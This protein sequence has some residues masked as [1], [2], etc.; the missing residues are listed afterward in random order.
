VYVQLYDDTG[1]PSGSRTGLT[2]STTNASRTVTS[3]NVYYI[4]VTP[5]ASGGSGTYRIGFT[6][7]TT[8]P[9]KIT[10]PTTGVTT[11]TVDVWADGNIAT[12][13]KEQWFKF[14]ATAATQYI[15][16]KSGEMTS[17]IV[18]LFDNTGTAVGNQ[19]T[20][21]NSSSSISRTVTV[22]NVYYIKVN[23]YSGTGAY[24]ILF[25]TSTVPTAIIPTTGVTT[26]TYDVWSN[27]IIA[28]SDGEQWFKFTATAA[29]QYIHFNRNTFPGVYVQ[30]YNNTGIPV[31]EQ[32]QIVNN[33]NISITVTNGSVYYIKATPYSSNGIYMIGFNNSSTTYPKIKI[34]TANVTTLSPDVWAN[35]NIDVNGEQWY[36]FTATS[37]RQHIHFSSGTLSEVYAA[38]YTNN[39]TI[40]GTPSWSLSSKDYEPVTIG[41]VY[42]IKVTPT[43]NSASGT[44]KIGVTSSEYVQ[45]EGSITLTLNVLSNGNITT[46]GG[47]QWFKFTAT[48][49]TQRVGFIPGTLTNIYIQMYNDTGTFDNREQL[50]GTEITNS[51]TFSV[52]VGNVYYVKVT[53]YDSSGSGTYQFSFANS[54]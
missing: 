37:G 34:P 54:N 14:T 21:P 52:T 53:P 12:A 41:S 16:F 15:H 31:G 32:V 40:I 50:Y 26:L 51:T 38:V 19:A 45:P 35:G 7:S 28:T 18:Q 39:G 27:G 46:A 22:G 43:T 5:T 8:V 10:L 49:A 30:L 33:N 24:K 47:V 4:K 25:N 42:Y 17:A 13:G 3:G 9:A 29:T 36:K 48:A 23:P 6:A 44:Y 1:T 11:L 20:L 2:S